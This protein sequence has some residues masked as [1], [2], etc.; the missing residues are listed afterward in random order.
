MVPIHIIFTAYQVIHRE[1]K[2]RLA[3]PWTMNKAHTNHPGNHYS[4]P[5]F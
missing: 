2:K 5:L 3:T 4:F 1:T